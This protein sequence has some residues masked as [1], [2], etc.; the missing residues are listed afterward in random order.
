MC[1]VFVQSENLAQIY[2]IVLYVFGSFHRLHRFFFS[3]MEVK[4]HNE[5]GLDKR[6]AISFLVFPSVRL[7]P[8]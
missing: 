5:N 4:I 6:L 7:S 8:F 3:S 1:L 2:E